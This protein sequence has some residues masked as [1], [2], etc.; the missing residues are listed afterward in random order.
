MKEEKK[1]FSYLILIIIFVVGIGLWAISLEVPNQLKSYPFE[2]EG[3][4]NADFIGVDYEMNFKNEE[5]NEKEKY[6]ELGSNLYAVNRT[7]YW[8]ENY[9]KHLNLKNIHGL[10]CNFRM[11]GEFPKKIIERL[12]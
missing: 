12:G 2:F 6:N 9:P 7:R 4:C 11:K 8:I 10:N 1:K 5:Y 3:K